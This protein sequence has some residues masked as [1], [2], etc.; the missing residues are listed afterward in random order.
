MVMIFYCD[1]L[2]YCDFKGLIG[3]VQLF[4][5]MMKIDFLIGYN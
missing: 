2:D 4:L 3:E 5:N 1:F